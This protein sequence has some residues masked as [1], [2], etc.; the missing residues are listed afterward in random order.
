MEALQ[1]L[2]IANC[3]IIN[4]LALI[5]L[6]NGETVV[7]PYCQCMVNKKVKETFGKIGPCNGPTPTFAHSPTPWPMDAYGG[8]FGIS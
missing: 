8:D 3:P 6:Q 5:V 7:F 4:P 2:I 1:H